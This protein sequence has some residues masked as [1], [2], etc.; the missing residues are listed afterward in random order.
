[1][2]TSMVLSLDLVILMVVKDVVS[3]MET[4]SNLVNDE[5]HTSIYTSVKTT[6]DNG[7]GFELDYMATDVNVNDNPQ[8]PSYPAL[9]YLGIPIMPGQAGSPFATPVLWIGV[10]RL[11]QR[12][13]LRLLQGKTKTLE[14]LWALMEF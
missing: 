9:S 5:D 13:H 1:M 8:S 12:S 6:L 3:I 2:Q 14:F 10:E 4:D 11:V 7:V